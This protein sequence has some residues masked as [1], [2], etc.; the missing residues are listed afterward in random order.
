[1]N[2]TYTKGHPLSPSVNLPSVSWSTGKTRWSKVWKLGQLCQPPTPQRIQRRRR[3]ELLPRRIWRNWYEQIFWFSFLRLLGSWAPWP[4][5]KVDSGLECFCCV[6]FW[7]FFLA[8]T[9]IDETLLK[10]FEMLRPYVSWHSIGLPAVQDL[11]GDATYPLQWWMGGWVGGWLLPAILA[12]PTPQKMHLLRGE[13]PQNDHRICIKFDPLNMGT[14]EWHF[15]TRRRFSVPGSQH[16]L[17]RAWGW[18]GERP[19]SLWAAEVVYR[20]MY[21]YFLLNMPILFKMYIHRFTYIH[22]FFFCIYI[23]LKI[24]ILTHLYYI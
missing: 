13:L 16:V 9:S 10:S 22:I 24:F 4:S 7:C 14:V 3:Q 23:F 2:K 5:A 20:N 1:M 6:F 18:K 11:G 8:Q 17:T 21:T 15:K 19:W 12:V